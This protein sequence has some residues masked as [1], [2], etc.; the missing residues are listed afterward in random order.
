[1]VDCNGD[2]VPARGAYVIA[3]MDEIILGQYHP[4]GEL[5]YYLNGKEITIGEMM[6]YLSQFVVLPEK[7]NREY[8][9]G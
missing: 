2:Q 3:K 7:V 1:M 8:D 5:H 4:S 6:S 9:H